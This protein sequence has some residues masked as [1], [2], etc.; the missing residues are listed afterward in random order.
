MPFNAY[1]KTRDSPGPGDLFS[2]RPPVPD[3]SV[4]SH[5]ALTATGDLAD[6][7][8]ATLDMLRQYIG[9]HGAPPT[10][11]EL[12]RGNPSKREMLHKR[13]PDLRAKGLVHN[14]GT[15]ACEV[16]GRS[17]MTWEPTK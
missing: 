16:T 1:T 5:R 7:C 3:T 15:R 12:A 17:A 14:P 8:A 13:L 6:Q 9:F 10:C 4:Q 11:G 2:A